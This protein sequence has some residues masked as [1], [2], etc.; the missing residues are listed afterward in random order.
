MSPEIYNQVI[1][2]NSQ[3]TGQ[4]FYYV[5]GMYQADVPHLKD[6]YNKDSKQYYEYAEIQTILLG[7]CSYLEYY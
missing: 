3:L 5:C 6:I 7:N 2:F 4:N 1:W